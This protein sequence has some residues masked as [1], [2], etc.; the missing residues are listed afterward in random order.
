MPSGPSGVLPVSE[1]D[2]GRG[3]MVVVM[4]RG[5]QRLACPRGRCDGQPARGRDGSGW[6]CP[7]AGPRAAAARAPGI[8]TRVGTPGSVPAKPA[9]LSLIAG[10][11]HPDRR[12]TSSQPGPAPEHDQNPATRLR[13]TR[14]TSVWE[15]G[16]APGSAAG[17]GASGSYLVDLAPSSVRAAPAPR[18]VV[19]GEAAALIS[20]VVSSSGSWQTARVSAGCSALSSCI[21]ERGCPCREP[22]R[23]ARRQARH[24]ALRSGDREG[25]RGGRRCRLR[26]GIRQTCAGHLLPATT[27]SLPPG[28]A[29]HDCSR[30]GPYARARCR[31]WWC[32]RCHGRE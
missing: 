8:G 1:G 32:R 19:W 22:A 3:A 16:Q 24:G 31:R 5:S 30:A 2:H 27:W 11:A 9:R 29:R 21:S 15:T 28:R 18:S 6:P 20:S 10:H 12:R 23:P 14:G 17:A 26:D 25:D 7:R 13:Q 4:L